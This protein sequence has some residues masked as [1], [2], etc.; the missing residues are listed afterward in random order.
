MATPVNTA[1]TQAD[2]RRLDAECADDT[3]IEV[4]DGIIFEIKRN[5]RW[6]RQFIVQNLYSQID[7][8]T[9]SRHLGCVFVIGVRYVL[10]GTP[11]KIADAPYPDFSFLRTGRMPKDFDPY[12]EFYGAPDL[13]VEVISP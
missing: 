5:S 4:E 9:L 2:L 13:A 7:A 6:M 12:G 10:I 3:R 1:I 8:F 11:E